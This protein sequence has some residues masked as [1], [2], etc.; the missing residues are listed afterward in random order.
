MNVDYLRE[1]FDYDAG[2]GHLVWRQ[3]PRAHFKNGAGWHNFNNQ[4]AGKIAGARRSNGRVEI[5]LDG[6]T[7]KAA[8]VI[9]AVYYGVSK[10]GIV[11][12]IDGNPGNDKIENLRL[13]TPAQNSRNRAHTAANSSGVR[14]VT[15]HTPSKKW[16]VRVT[17]DGRTRS[18]GLYK[19]LEQAVEVAR[20]AKQRL[21]GDFA[22][23]A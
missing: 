23:H 20:V 9:W 3:R 4:C 6:R 10:F 22:R 19:S 11:D 21:F 18:F 17:L 15:W 14:G 5:T 8:R 1:C 12:H 7:Y 2:A 13:A 16:W